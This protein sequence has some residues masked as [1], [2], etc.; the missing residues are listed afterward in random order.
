[1]EYTNEVITP[2]EAGEDSFDSFPEQ[3]T[4]TKTEDV[5]LNELQLL[6][7][8]EREDGHP[9]PVG[10]YSER[11]VRQKLEILTGVIP[12]SVR[13]INAYDT[14]VEVTAD[15]SVSAIAQS[16]HH[17]RDW[18]NNPVRIS[19]LLGSSSY[20]GEVCRQRNLIIEQQTE[21]H[22][23]EERYRHSLRDKETEVQQLADRYREAL[24]RQAEDMQSQTS[25]QKETIAQLVQKMDHQSRLVEELRTAQSQMDSIPRISSSIITPNNMLQPVVQ[26]MTRSPD[27]PN[28]SGELPTPKGEVEYD[29]WIFQIKNLRKTYTDNAIRNGVV[30]CVR[31]LANMIVRS[32]G[33]DSTLDRIIQCLDEK[34][35]RTETDDHLLQEFHQMQQGNCERV[36]EYGSKLECKFRFLQERFPTRYDDSQLRDRF[37]SSIKDKTRD[38]IRHKYDRPDCTF[39]E[40]MT[41]A[42]K[43]EAEST[44]KIIRS[45]AA[46]V[47]LN[48]N[49]NPELVSIQKQLTSMSDILQKARNHSK[50]QNNK[51]SNSQSNAKDDAKASKKI[52]KKDRSSVQCHRCLGWGHFIRDCPSKDPVEGSV[53]WEQLHGDPQQEVA[54]ASK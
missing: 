25:S 20:L 28:F 23:Q 26:K 3:Q 13:R 52:I 6:I 29:N 43:V 15:T 16:L 32:A 46:C 45:K 8:I 47:D 24:A 44:S 5:V 2:Q 4:P 38:A 41:A 30:S 17:V 40:L 35:S 11:C 14:I 18:E 53:E 49:T 39:N 42:M 34:F 10:T 12:E 54:G 27:L 50:S 31:G 51:G 7:R 22:R 48:T 36:L 21:I 33:Y 19:C 37:F 1:M 9:L